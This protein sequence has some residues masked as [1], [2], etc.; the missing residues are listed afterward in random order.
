M[1]RQEAEFFVA[2]VEAIIKGNEREKVRHTLPRIRRLAE[3]F[4]VEVPGKILEIKRGWWQ[5]WRNED[6][7]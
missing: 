2:C 7:V 3:G 4:P 1:T 5:R 6:R